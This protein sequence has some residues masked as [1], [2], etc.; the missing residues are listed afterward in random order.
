MPYIYVSVRE[1]SADEK[2]TIMLSAE[3]QR[4]VSRAGRVMERALA[5]DADIFTDYTG[6]GDAVAE[7]ER[8]AALTLV[9]S[10]YDERWSRGRC[11]TSLDWSSAHP[12]LLLASY[13]NSDD[14]PHDPD[15]VALVWNT[16]FKKTTPEDI[17]HCQ[18]PVMSATFAR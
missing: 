18:S 14:A 2:Q 9:R 17:F 16:K 11:T 7:E 6:G 12:E 10:F 8:G 15:G 13:H 4:F 1:L 3:F 5:E